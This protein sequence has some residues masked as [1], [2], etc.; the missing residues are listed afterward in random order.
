MTREAKERRTLMMRKIVFRVSISCF[1]I[2]LIFSP[3]VALTDVEWKTQKEIDL[4]AEPLD[5]F[6]SPDG[7]LLFI[8]TRGEVLVYSVRHEKITEKIPVDQEFDRITYS[9]QTKSL[10]LTSS[11]KKTLRFVSLDFIQRID[12]SGLPFKGPEDAPIAVA[13]FSDY[14]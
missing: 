11:Q 2:S 4:K 8:L 6:Q 12:I 14:Q 9:P 13:V 5:I 7:L 3:H 1:C 10:T